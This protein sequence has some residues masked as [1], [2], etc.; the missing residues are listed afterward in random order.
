VIPKH[1]QDHAD[2]EYVSFVWINRKG[3]KF[4]GNK[5]TNSLTYSQSTLY[6]NTDLPNEG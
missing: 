2:L 1:S 3:A 4:I 6:I 5:Q